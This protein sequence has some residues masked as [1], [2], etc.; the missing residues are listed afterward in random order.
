MTVA[1][2][3]MSGQ[4]WVGIESVHFHL[5]IT[6]FDGQQ[7]ISTHACGTDEIHQSYGDH[8]LC[9]LCT[10]STPSFNGI[11]INLAAACPDA[12]MRGRIADQCLLPADHLYPH[13]KRG[14]PSVSAQA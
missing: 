8:K 12:T 2:L 9:T 11:E 4:L 7:S 6:D 10:R 1:L 14:P 3:L 13:L 5:P